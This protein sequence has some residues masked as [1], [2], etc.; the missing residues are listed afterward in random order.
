LRRREESGL[1]TLPLRCG[2][3]E[4][5]G[6]WKWKKGRDVNKERPPRTLRLLFFALTST[7]A[8]E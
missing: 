4:A 2:L 7:R 1:I 8:E 3:R 6:E 5:G